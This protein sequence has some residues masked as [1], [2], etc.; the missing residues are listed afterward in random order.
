[1]GRKK[2][3]LPRRDTSAGNP[4]WVHGLAWRRRRSAN[5]AASPPPTSPDSRVAGSG[6]CVRPPPSTAGVTVGRVTVFPDDV[7]GSELCTSAAVAAAAAPPPPEPAAP[8]SGGGVKQ[9]GGK[10]ASTR[11]TD[12]ASPVIDTASPIWSHVQFLAGITAHDLGFS[13]TMNLLFCSS[14]SGWVRCRHGGPSKSGGGPLQNRR[15]VSTR[16]APHDGFEVR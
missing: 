11:A 14:L 2:R 1:M 6:V 8:G 9:P 12:K 16:N 10:K 15:W 7:P 5:R 3:N 4:V 13:S